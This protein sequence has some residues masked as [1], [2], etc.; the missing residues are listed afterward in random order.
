V[1]EL[2]R[3]WYKRLV[4]GVQDAEGWARRTRAWL[5]QAS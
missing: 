4:L 2:R 5:E 1:I 3:G